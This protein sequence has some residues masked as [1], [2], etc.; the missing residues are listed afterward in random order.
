MPDGPLRR[1]VKLTNRYGLHARPA[2]L[3]VETCSRYTCEVLVRKG[4][5]EVSGK[6]IL[7]IMTL[8]AEP[9]SEL[10]L[11]FTGL[12]AEEAAQ[13]VVALVANNFGET[14]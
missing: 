12:D 8:G 14:S 7:A 10:D 13:A 3:F 2:A 5:Q 6:N 1:R 9:G 4:D 11:S